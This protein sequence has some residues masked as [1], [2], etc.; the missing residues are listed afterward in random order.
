MTV[1][2]QNKNRKPKLNEV[3]TMFRR[4]KKRRKSSGGGFFKFIMELLE[5]I[6]D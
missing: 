3:I 6:F 4:R 2:S 5:S 1:E